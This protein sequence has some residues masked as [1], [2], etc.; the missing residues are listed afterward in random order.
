MVALTG[1]LGQK[2]ERLLASPDIKAKR[3][4]AQRAP[5]GVRTRRD[6]DKPTVRRLWP[7]LM[8]ASG[9]GRLACSACLFPSAVVASLETGSFANAALTI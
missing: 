4:G 8:S 2:L 6:H 7:R 3:L 9:G 5:V 1:P